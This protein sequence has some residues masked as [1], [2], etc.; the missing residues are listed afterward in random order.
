M[1][2]VLIGIL[3]LPD[4][5]GMININLVCHRGEYRASTPAGLN[6]V[7]G[8]PWVFEAPRELSHPTTTVQKRLEGA[9]NVHVYTQPG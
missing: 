5:V 9:M 4:G 8:Y 6:L 3:D 2:A 1:T 7:V